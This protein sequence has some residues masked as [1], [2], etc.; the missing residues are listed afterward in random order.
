MTTSASLPTV[1]TQ[2]PIRYCNVLSNKTTLLSKQC[3]EYSGW[4][5]TRC[6]FC[7]TLFQKHINEL[8]M[9]KLLLISF[10]MF[11][12]FSMAACSSSDNEPAIPEQ[13]EKPDGDDNKEHPDTPSPDG[14]AR[15]LVL[16]ASRSEIPSA[17]RR[18]FAD[19]W[20]AMCSRLS[21]KRPTTMIITPCC[22]VHRRN[23][24][25]YAEVII[26]R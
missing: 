15:C 7:R 14:S 5:R 1:I 10:L 16:Y 17:W 18:K 21:R 25:A 9:R 11:A 24:T 2:L 19:N 8:N 20:I 13:P 4:K 23:L 3:Q 26:H 22:P 6:P 12:M